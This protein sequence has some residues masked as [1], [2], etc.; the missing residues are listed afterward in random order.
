MYH[1]GTN[2]QHPDHTMAECQ[3]SRA[4]N[5]NDMPHITYDFQS[6]L[7]EMGQPNWTAFHQT[8][9]LHQFLADWGEEL[10]RMDVDTLSTM[11]AEAASSFAMTMSAYST[12]RAQ[13]ASP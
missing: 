6:P 10:S 4:T 3:A 9:W 2:P 12:N 1:G 8:R 7:G 11:H 5:Y 13:Q